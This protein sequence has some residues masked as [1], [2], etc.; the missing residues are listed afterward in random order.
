MRILG[1]DLASRPE[2][3]GACLTTWRPGEATADLRTGPL[4]DADLLRLAETADVVAVDAPLGW[5]D[6]FVA[7]VAAHQRGEPWPE[8][9]LRELR[10]RHTDLVVWKRTAIAP[11]SVSSDL[12]GVCAFRAARL[13][14]P[15]RRRCPTVLEVYPAG[16]LR[17]WQLPAVGYKGLRGR[18]TRLA[19]ITELL[20]RLPWL[21]VDREQL[22]KRDHDLD[23]LLCTLVGRA[24]ATGRTFAPAP[25]DS[26]RAGREGWIELPSCP[27]EELVLPGTAA[28]VGE[29]PDP[30]RLR[31]G[32][33]SRE[34]L[35]PGAV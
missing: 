22:I 24:A 14:R 16:A 19:L 10:Y 15:L 21:E 28:G 5:P 1:I 12:I 33:R 9:D 4:D 8:H 27:P 34:P 18:P 13:L 26:E 3:T 6:P 20:A 30:P 31:S 17:W 29:P 11:L 23:A 25:E 2:S 7:A 32:R 35:G